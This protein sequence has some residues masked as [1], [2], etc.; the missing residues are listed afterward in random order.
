MSLRVCY[1]YEHK[2]DYAAFK[3]PVLKVFGAKRP[4]EQFKLILYFV[5]RRFLKRCSGE[6]LL[7]ESSAGQAQ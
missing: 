3:A 6:A 4:E 7:V 2:N 5:T 1:D